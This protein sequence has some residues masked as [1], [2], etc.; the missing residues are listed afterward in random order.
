L[1]NLA[2]LTRTR[3]KRVHERRYYQSLG[4]QKRE[5]LSRYA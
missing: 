2:Y 1:V 3:V 4:R 5:D